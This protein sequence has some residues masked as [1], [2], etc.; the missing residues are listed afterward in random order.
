MRRL[1]CASFAIGLVL[2]A[3]A[4]CRA[5]DPAEPRA[6]IEKAIQAR[7]GAAKLNQFKAAT[8]KGAGKFHG[9]GEAIDLTGEWAVQPPEQSRSRVEF[10]FNGMKFQRLVVVN[11]DKGWVKLNDAVQDMDKEQLAEEK[12]L[13]Y[14]VRLTPLVTDKAYQLAP[15]GETKIG[16]RPA[17]GVKA[18]HKDRRD[19]N[20][21]FDKETGLLLKSE[22][23]VRDVLT[24]QEVGQETFYSDYKE[25]GGLKHPMKIIIRRDDRPFLEIQWSDFQP[26]DKLDDGV[27]A[28]P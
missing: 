2:G 26:H 28:K 25:V 24:G 20:L 12:S 4:P 21:Y 1:W 13:A 19:V 10:E 6:L 14:A 9:L 18:S 22:T 7:G 17:V 27:F 8:W 23:R 16:D 11:G 3:I 5:D 15:L